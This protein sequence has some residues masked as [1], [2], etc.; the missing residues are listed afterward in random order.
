M[1]YDRIFQMTLMIWVACMLCLTDGSKTFIMSFQRDLKVPDSAS[2]EVWIEYKNKIH[3]AKEITVCH[4]IKI[5]YF[6]F[7]YSACLWSYCIQKSNKDKMKCLRLC[8]NG[9]LNTANREVI[10]LAQIPSN[11][12]TKYTSAIIKESVHRIWSHICWSFSAITGESSFYHDGG[13]IKME[14]VNV[15]GLDNAIMDAEGMYDKAFIFGQEPDIIRGAYDKNEAFLGDLA[16]FNIW[17]KRLVAHDVNRM[18]SCKLA[19]QGNILAWEKSNFN[20]YNV[21]VQESIDLPELCIKPE[22]YVIFPVKLSYPDAK[23]ICKIH[24]G[25]L[26]LPKS[27]AENQ[28]I[29]KIVFK[30][31]ETCIENKQSGLSY[32]TWIG[33]KKQKQK[34][35]DLDG[36]GGHGDPLNYTNVVQAGST[37][38]TDCAYL[39]TDGAWLDSS[40]VCNKR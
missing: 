19:T 23:Q 39:Q 6:N 29:V 1:S 33:A 26:A 15:E 25:K 18:A 16:E 5:R 7:K 35:Y 17:S 28:K 27:E 12:G 8:I 10:L 3:P 37:P 9:V 31:R 34:W 11:K 36:E 40:N 4:W 21:D 32:A 22:K 13:L 20:L 14:N 24:G 30:H 2:N 38:T